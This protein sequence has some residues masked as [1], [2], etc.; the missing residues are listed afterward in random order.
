MKWK[1]SPPANELGCS[2]FDPLA[3]VYNDKKDC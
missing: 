2:Y 3:H 1:G